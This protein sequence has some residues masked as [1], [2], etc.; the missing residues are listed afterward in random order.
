MPKIDLDQLV[1]GAALC[2]WFGASPSFHDTKLSSLE[3]RQGGDSVIVAHIFRVGP[4]VDGEGYYVQSKRAVVTFTLRELIEV[5]L[6]EF[7]EAG[8]M[9]GLE[10]ERDAEGITL[11]FDASY[12]VHGHIKAVGV[13]LAF[14]PQ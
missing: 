8:I 10:I 3:I 14:A 7:M 2:E 5:E 9:D 12:G 4:E 1:G 13:S 11:R 6:Y